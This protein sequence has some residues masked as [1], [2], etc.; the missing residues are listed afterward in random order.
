M[1]KDPDKQKANRLAW[2][3]ANPEKRKASRE[4]DKEKAR[5]RAKQWR[6]DNPQ[7]VIE[8]NKRA[9]QK[10]LDKCSKE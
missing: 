4:K 3:Q 8:N 5:L 1:Y 9:Y 6:L 10:R 7:K 2:E